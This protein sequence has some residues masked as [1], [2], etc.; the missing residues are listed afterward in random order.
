[1]SKRRQARR[2]A[3]QLLYQAEIW[4]GP[5]LPLE[6]VNSCLES[7]ERDSSPDDGM[8][9]FVIEAVYGV[10]ERVDELDGMIAEYAQYWTIDRMPVIDKNIL[11]LALRELLY[12]SDIPW[13]VSINEAV[14]LAKRYSTPECASFVNGVLSAVQADRPSGESNEERDD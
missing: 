14:E 3:V 8:R 1:M 11:R 6:D 7:W 5:A 13:Q 2:A 10:S 9:T 12:C 4:G